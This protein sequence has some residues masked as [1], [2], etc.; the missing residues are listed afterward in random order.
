MDRRW[1]LLG[2]ALGWLTLP[3][4]ADDW[5]QWRGPNRDARVTAFN[6]P[7]KWPERLTQK[8][9]VTVGDGVATPALAGGKL[10]VFSRQGN[11]EMTRCLDATTGQEI[12]QDKHDVGA[13]RGR[14]DSGFPGP[15]ASPTVAE[16]K[17]LTLGVEGNLSCLDA[18]T[19][20]VVWRNDDYKGNHPQ[21]HTS[22]SPIVVDGLC[23]AQ[24]GGERDGA[25]VAYD[26]ATGK[27]KWK[28]TGDGT[29][30]ASPV[31]LPINGI[32]AV[33]TQTARHVVAVNAADG[34]LLWQ[35]PFVPGGMPGGGRGRSYNAAT[36]MVQDQTVI[37]SGGGR[38]TK[39]IQFEKQGDNLTAKEL[40]NNPSISVQF[41]TPVLKDGRVFG[42][43]QNDDLFCL[44]ANTGKTLWTEGIGGSGRYR[45]YGSV[46]DAGSVLF[47][48]TPAGRLF[49]FEP[50]V[51][52]FKQLAS[53]PVGSDTF[54]YPV[55]AGNR[56]YVKDRDSLTLW[57]IE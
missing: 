50:S 9:K 47:A 18:A 21:F 29:A 17:V 39:A 6:T 26:L 31:L 54:A 13:F 7:P 14:G 22:S 38:G 3:I 49:V 51:K 57:T 20:K 5:P 23:I 8:W 40:W 46:V 34:R 32:Q 56:I 53:Y 37:Y 1:F 25:I 35:T 43:T 28:W 33:V 44:D 12:W 24:L 11:N 52:D 15:R 41:N 4:P 36:P 48:L 16:G 45:G 10:Y 55:I 2:V 42:L 27:E 30:Y 19:G